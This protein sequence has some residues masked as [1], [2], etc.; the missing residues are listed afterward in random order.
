MGARA[1]ILPLPCL[2][3]PSRKSLLLPLPPAA[4]P[5]ASPPA[6]ELGLGR[7]WQ[8]GL[9][10]GVRLAPLTQ[11]SPHTAR[12]A[13][14]PCI[15]PVLTWRRREGWWAPR[16]RELL[17]TLSNSILPLSFRLGIYAVAAGEHAGPGQLETGQPRGPASRPHPLATTCPGG[18]VSADAG[19]DNLWRLPGSPAP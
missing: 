16:G 12:G 6:R 7:Q 4:R 13:A 1:P 9:E 18:R 19:T 14:S 17:C 15:L 11:N 5:L 8:R 2:W 10:A 3:A